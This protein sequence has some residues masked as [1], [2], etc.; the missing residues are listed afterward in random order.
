MSWDEV[1]FIIAGRVRRAVLEKLEREM[2]PTALAHELGTSLANVSRALR[3]LQSR[4]LVECLTPG[5]RV[6]KIFSA[7]K[8]GRAVLLRARQMQERDEASPD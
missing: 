8:K 4:G 1:S 7:T 2:T 3:E 5:A 6:G